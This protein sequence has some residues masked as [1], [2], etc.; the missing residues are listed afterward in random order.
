MDNSVH[1]VEETN[2]FLEHIRIK[3]VL[4]ATL[5]CFE[6]LLQ[7]KVHLYKEAS[8]I[9]VICKIL[10]ISRK[11]CNNY[12]K[13]AKLKLYRY[14]AIEKED[15]LLYESMIEEYEDEFD[16]KFICMKE[17][18]EKLAAYINEFKG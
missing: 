17:N 15:I 16:I 11:V 13:I 9:S 10:G 3:L 6:E 7:R 1:L 2:S 12:L 14:E 8:F 4:M 5:P 18:E